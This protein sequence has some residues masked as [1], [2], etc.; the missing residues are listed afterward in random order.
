MGR[1]VT[2]AL[3]WSSS[4]TLVPPTTAPILRPTTPDRTLGPMVGPSNRGLPC[5]LTDRLPPTLVAE[6]F[7]CL[8]EC[9][10]ST[11]DLEE[12][13]LRAGRYTALTVAGENIMT[14][15]LLDSHDLSDILTALCG[16]S[17]YAY[18]Q[19]IAEGFLTLP[20]GIRVGVAGRASLE[21]R[22]ILGLREVT[23]LCIRLPHH[24]RATGRQLA[25]MLRDSL[26]TGSARG[27][28]I[29]GPPGVG[30]TTLLRSLAVEL[31]SPPAPLRTVLVDTRAELCYDTTDPCLSLDVL[32]GYPR[33]RGVE[34]ATRTLSAQVI[35]CDEIG[36]CTEAMSLT[37]AHRGGVPLVASAHAADRSELLRRTGLRLLHE[38]QLFSGYVGLARDG[39]GG[40]RYTITPW[41]IADREL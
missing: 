39:R 12:I 2:T 17:L 3:G 20:E 31:S 24:G 23:G 30:K 8:N 25:Q 35:L 14:H 28:L 37:E 33:A 36:D 10:V 29:Y 13:R 41:E 15:L 19:D 9:G 6:L 4:S 5:A 38:A 22:Q 11:A 34:I 21:G 7:D 40:F 18:S 26:A 16:G 1:T 32:V 27:I